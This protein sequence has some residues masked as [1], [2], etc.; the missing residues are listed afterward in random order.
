MFTLYESHMSVCSGKVRLILEE[1]G[2]DYEEI[3]IDLGKGEQLTDDYLKLNPKGVVP[4]LIHDDLV[5]R[6]STVIMQ[7]LDDILPEPALTPA[8]PLARMKMRYWFKL[9]DEEVHPHTSTVTAAVALRH[10]RAAKNTPEQLEAN[11]AAMPNPEKAARNRALQFDGIEA[12][13]FRPAIK[14]LEKM[15]AGIE[16]AL[17]EGGGEFLLGDTYSLADA[18]VTPYVLRLE[19]LGFDAMLGDGRVHLPAWWARI[20][21]RPN[22]RGVVSPAT[23]PGLAGGRRKWGEEAWPRVKEILAAR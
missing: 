5:V 9:I 1:K 3:A 6:E 16:D 8:D 12:D 11:F 14:S 19:T 23:P 4:T 2:V 10:E 15:L 7:Y 20:K 21:A 17:A 22:F 13:I 18:A